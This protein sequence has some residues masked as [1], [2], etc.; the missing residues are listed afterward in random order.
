MKRIYVSVGIA[1]AV[2]LLSKFNFTTGIIP[3]DIIISVALLFVLSYLVQFP[4]STQTFNAIDNWEKILVFV[5]ISFCNM[6]IIFM[7][8][9]LFAYS[10]NLTLSQ[11]LYV[12]LALIISIQ[13][14]SR[15]TAIKFSNDTYYAKKEN[16]SYLNLLFGISIIVTLFLGVHYGGWL[17]GDYTWHGTYIRKLREVSPISFRNYLVNNLPFP[18]YGHNIWHLFLAFLS[19]VSGKDTGS[20]WIYHNLFLII[21]RISVYYLLA[22]EMF[23][24]SY[25]GRVS[26]IIFLIYNSFLAMG[27]DGE[28][29]FFDH[30]WSWDFPSPSELSREI[31]LN[32]LLYY[33][34]KGINTKRL[35]RKEIFL[36]S[37][38]IALIHFFYIFHL[39]FILFAMF[40]FSWFFCT[41]EAK[42]FR[43]HLYSYA[44]LL[45]PAVAYA[46]IYKNLLD[47]PT[48]NTSFTTTGVMG[49]WRNRIIY[50][51]NKYPLVHPWRG[52]LRDPFFAVAILSIIPMI[53]YLR[54]NRIT[55]FKL[56][57][58]SVT[59]C[60]AMIF[61][62]PPLMFYLQKLNPGLD[63]VWR[64]AES[65]PLEFILAGC[66]YQ[67]NEE[68]KWIKKSAITGFLYASIV[69]LFPIF[70]KYHSN[71]VYDLSLEKRT[72]EQH[73]YYKNILEK[74][75]AP[76]KNVFVDPK[77]AWTW[78]TIFPHYLYIHPYPGG[79]PP[80]YD[81]APR[82]NLWK[83]FF[84]S[85]ISLDMLKE[86]KNSKMEYIIL[87]KETFEK[88]RKE[89]EDF[90]DYY[91]S[92]YFVSELGLVV[93]KMK[94]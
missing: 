76:G 59:L 2:V 28:T 89:I 24:S 31:F 16:R 91:D 15:N 84:E 77:I 87:T 57:L 64:F 10:F 27:P 36:F 88:K 45:I 23:R 92:L 42:M 20:I 29:P 65:L 25:W 69:L 72:I 21:V 14:Y 75:V 93:I 67:L 43:Q 13:I 83:S 6:M 33:I 78:T 41:E 71:I 46:F 38:C 51:W 48:V 52:F 17:S 66:L 4:L 8:P 9:A 35:F 62:N 22:K 58:I 82:L 90:K 26:I 80:N 44:L 79:L 74:Y 34:F 63:R 32:G 81:P 12:F 49:D 37:L 19:F 30:K 50:L 11:L 73:I 86:L 68:N 60:L 1:S 85:K 3:L 40:V 70:Q 54:K 39:I 94:N 18:Q 56:Y 61:F 5:F 53:V 55:F 7:L 47:N